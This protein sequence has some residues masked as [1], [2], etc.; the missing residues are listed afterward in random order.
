MQSA[1]FQL[2]SPIFFGEFEKINKTVILIEI[3]DPRLNE[4][5]MLLQ[6]KSII[7]FTELLNMAAEAV[8][9]QLEAMLCS[10][11]LL[12]QNCERAIKTLEVSLREEH[13]A[14]FLALRAY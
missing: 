2:R 5:R 8:V 1:Y 12:L 10:V 14:F 9:D 7:T 13:R 3:G 4:L 6:P 11:I